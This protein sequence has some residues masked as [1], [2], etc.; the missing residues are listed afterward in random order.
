MEGEKKSFLHQC[1]AVA[2]NTRKEFLYSPRKWM[3]DLSGLSY[4]KSGL[5]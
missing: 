5:R 3:V 1:K 2:E 4:N